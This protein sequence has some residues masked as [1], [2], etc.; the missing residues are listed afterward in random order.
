MHKD[1]RHF[2]KLGGK[3]TSPLWSKIVVFVLLGLISFS[4]YKCNSLNE[5]SKETN[6]QLDNAL[7][8]IDNVLKDPRKR[9]LLECKGI[10]PYKIKPEG[11]TAPTKQECDVIEKQLEAEI[12]R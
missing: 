4:F 2:Q 7:K 10:D 6:V 3:V 1:I 12:K 11:W 8:D 5:A 9:R